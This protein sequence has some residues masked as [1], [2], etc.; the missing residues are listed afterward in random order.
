MGNPK[1]TTPVLKKTNKIAK[2]ETQVKI[3]EIA[4]LIAEK[5][6][7][8]QA[9]IKYIEEKFGVGRTQSDKYYHAAMNM[10][11]PEDPEKYRETLIARNFAVLES[12]L[13]RALETNDLSSATQIV[14]I[15][16][17]MLNVG[18]KKVQLEQGDT[19]ITVSFGE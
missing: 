17:T 6:Y 18:D 2:Y 11:L 10:L 9:C 8:R 4:E 19:K 15:M 1:Q 12:M 13:Q 5:G 16:N 3:K 7:G 14:K